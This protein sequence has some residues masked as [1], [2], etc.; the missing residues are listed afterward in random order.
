MGQPCAVKAISPAN[1][2]YCC[3]GKARDSGCFVSHA[4][5]VVFETENGKVIDVSKA[6]AWIDTRWLYTR[7]PCGDST[8]E[9]PS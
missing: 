2:N 5:F 1:G 6:C 4:D 8:L 9:A 3:D 7:S